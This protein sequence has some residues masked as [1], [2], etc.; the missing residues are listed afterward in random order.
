MK[1]RL[2]QNNEGEEPTSRKGENTIRKYL[3]GNLDVDRITLVYFL[4]FWESGIESRNEIWIT[5][6]RNNEILDE[7]GFSMLGK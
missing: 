7:C 6:K 2:L 3:C 4:L 5:E 1:I